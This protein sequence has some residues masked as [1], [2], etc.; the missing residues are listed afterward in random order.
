MGYAQ[1]QP[2]MNFTRRLSL[3]FAAGFA[4]IILTIS[5][6]ADTFNFSYTFTEV[7][8]I[9][10]GTLTGTQ[11]GNFVDS[12]NITSLFI[13][14]Y[15]V[16]GPSYPQLHLDGPDWTGGQPI[17]SF[18]NRF[19][20]FRIIDDAGY[21]FYIYNYPGHQFTFAIT[22]FPP[23]YYAFDDHQTGN[24]GWNLTNASSVPDTSATVALLGVSFLGLAALRR[25]F[26]A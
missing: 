16:S 15:D 19:N 18:D 25:R 3:G 2:N 21:N 6:Q 9:V 7:P 26:A 8:G 5:A 20:N 12:A 22:D 1:N 24:A 10:S 13:N 11:N 17:I 14:G 4:A 23:L